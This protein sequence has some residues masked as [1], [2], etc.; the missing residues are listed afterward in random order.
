GDYGEY[1][2]NAQR[3]KLAALE[4]DETFRFVL[5]AITLFQ[6]QLPSGFELSITSDFSDQV[7][8]GSSAAVTV[9]ANAALSSWITGSVDPDALFAASFD[10]IRAV[11]GRGSCADV[12]ASVFGG[13]V[14]YQVEPRILQRLPHFFDISVVYSGG[15][16]PTLE[17]IDK[18]D[19]LAAENP[20]LVESVYDS[21]AS[22]V[23]R[24][25]VSI[26]NE[27]L[28]ELGRILDEGQELMSSL[29]LSN[30]RLSDIV[31]ALRAEKDI[32]GAKISGAGLGDCV[33]ALGRVNNPSFV[34]DLLPLEID[35][36]GVVI[37]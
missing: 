32:L 33:I 11:Q 19:A 30:D 5:A 14:H 20:G 8:L 3:D 17:V 35:Q 23:K 34:H 24:A 28:E 37:D 6:E 16:I 27:N 4:P 31:C 18:V 15:K 36:K 26:D 21:M 10:V 22:C 7:G 9:G 12:A 1:C 2:L 29:G 13:V 25:V